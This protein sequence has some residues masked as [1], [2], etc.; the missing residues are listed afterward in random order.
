[1]TKIT[2]REAMIG[3]AAVAAASVAGVDEAAAEQERMNR[4]IHHLRLAKEQLQHARRNKGG[5][6]EKAIRLIDEAL[7][8]VHRGKQFARGT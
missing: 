2:R 3:S 8:E 4:A 6:R 5:H 1:M 7:K